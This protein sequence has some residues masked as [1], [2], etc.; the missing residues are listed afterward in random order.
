VLFNS[1]EFIFAFFPITF[2]VFWLLPKRQYRLVWL[3]VASYVFYGYWD[4][5]FMALM[6]LDTAI[7]YFCG[8]QI[9]RSESPGRRK[10]FLLLSLIG[11]LG[12]LAYF[13]YVDFF[14]GSVNAVAMQI[15]L[16]S[17]L[18]MLG[19]ILPIGISFYTFQALSYTI[20][21][22]R[23]EAHEAPSFIMFACY[24]SMFPQLIAGPIVRYVQVADQLEN[25]PDRPGGDR[26]TKGIWFFVMGLSKKVLIADVIARMINPMFA[27]YA[28]LGL[29]QSW[30]VVL[31]YTVQIYFDFAGYSDMAVGLGYFVGLKMPQNF[32]SPYKALNISDFW[33]RWHISLSTWLRDYLFIPLGGSRVGGGRTLVN[34]MVVM[35]L[36]GMWHG[37]TWGFIVWGLYHG[38]LLVSHATF[39]KM[40]GKIRWAPLSRGITFVA[41]VLGWAIF[42]TADP[43]LGFGMT[44]Q[45]LG[46]MVG[47]NGVESLGALRSLVGVK[48][49]LLVAAALA[50]C[51][52]VPNTWD[53][54]FK[55]S[56]RWAIASALMFCA[57]VLL[58][59]EKSPFLYF[60]F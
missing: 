21:L 1:A 14:L 12:V 50:W 33:R 36:G 26:L 7:C 31:G 42:R 59:A 40:G 4:Y 11:C 27:D 16:E 49:P 53:I 9:A 39:S 2:A 44:R 43:G 35:F 3:T 23:R 22:Y 56:R 57:C 32:N 15:G 13:K 24:V 20:D 19:V 29:F 28:S 47:A 58:L 45:L 48:L 10:F 51:F 60:Q 25:L 34:L 41:V 54:Q 52:W 46:S 8:Q 30:A 17:Q 55:P 5:R 18:P 38:V 6:L 37:A